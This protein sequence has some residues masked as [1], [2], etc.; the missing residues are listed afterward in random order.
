[1]RTMC[2]IREEEYFVRVKV[3]GNRRQLRGHPVVGRM[4]EECGACLGML[5]HR[6]FH[7]FVRY[8]HRNPEPCIDLRS[9]PDRPHPRKDHRADDGA[10]CIAR[11]E[12][13]ISGRGRRHQHRVDSTRRP[14][15]HKVC[16]IR[17][18]CARRQ[19]LRRADA[20]RRRMEVIELRRERDIRAQSLVRQQPTQQRMRPSPALVPWCVIRPNAKSCIAEQRFGDRCAHKSSVRRL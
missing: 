9:K 13:G 6:V 4:D 20:A 14:V 1:M 17:T 19:L 8:A 18:V 5:P 11:H 15:H 3:R 10:V 16:C 7:R 12:N 2:S